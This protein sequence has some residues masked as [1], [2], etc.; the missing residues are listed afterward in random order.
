M[1][2]SFLTSTSTPEEEIRKALLEV[3]GIGPWSCDM[4]LI[5]H[6]EMP[7]VFPIGDLAV[8]KGLSKLYFHS[9]GMDPKTHVPA[10]SR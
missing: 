3:K 9:L 2:E 8:R 1:T 4:F 10:L 6:L 5:F 7:D